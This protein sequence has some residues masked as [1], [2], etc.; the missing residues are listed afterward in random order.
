MSGI[1]RVALAATVACA[2]CSSEPPPQ[3][4]NLVVITIDTLRADRVGAIAPGSGVT[5][6]IDAWARDAIVFEQAYTSVPLTLPAHVAMLSGLLPIAHTVRTNDGRRVPDDVPLVADALRSAGFDTAA[7]VGA[8]VLDHRS[9]LARGF[10]VYDD[11][12]GPSGERRADAVVERARAWLEQNRQQPFF[13]WVHFY[14]PHLDYDPPEPY[15]T[16]FAGREYDGEVADTDAAVGRL[17]EALDRANVASQ[18]AVI[19]TGDHGE[20]LGEHGERSHGALLFEGATRVPLIIRVPG[21]KAARVASPV[22]TM[23][24]APTLLQLAGVSGSADRS[25]SGAR[26]LYDNS[27]PMARPSSRVAAPRSAAVKAAA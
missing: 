5:P 15:R 2:A 24:I 21:A 23:A 9:G 27:G 8:A 7:F 22:S 25:G 19:L 1:R 17:F 26:G 18:T 14:D 16:R 20:S 10:E 11:E 3:R 13:L 12:V 4:F 6:V